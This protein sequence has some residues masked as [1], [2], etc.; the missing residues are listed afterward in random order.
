VTELPD[1]A[2]YIEAL[3]RHVGGKVLDRVRVVNPF[4]VRTYDPPLDEGFGK[5]EEVV[6]ERGYRGPERAA[7]F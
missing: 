2:I 7:S 1:I 4:P 5:V 6:R 3:Q